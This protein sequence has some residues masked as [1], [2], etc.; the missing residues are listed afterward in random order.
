MSRSGQG[1]K[2]KCRVSAEHEHAKS[3]RVRKSM[4]VHE[5]KASKRGV[6][7]GYGSDE[8]WRTCDVDVDGWQ[9]VSAGRDE[10]PY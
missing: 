3:C 5:A 9:G 6:R 10:A 7:R 1:A 8:E 2:C 4:Q